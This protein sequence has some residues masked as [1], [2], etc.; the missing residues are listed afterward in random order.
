MSEHLLVIEDSMGIAKVIEKLG[1]SLGYQVTIATTLAQVKSLL[2]NKND[3]FL[4]TVDYGLPDALD[5]EA[6]QF[7]LEHSIPS[8]VMTGRMDDK[9]RQKILNLPVVDYI[10]KENTQAYHYLLRILHCQLTNREISVL[11]VDD[12]L[13]SRNQVS[14]LL[15]RRNFNVFSVEDGTKALALLEEHPEIKIVITDQAMPGMDGLEL[16]QKI[17]KEHSQN[18]L[19]IIGLSDAERSFESARFIKNGADDFLRKP[20]CQ[21]EFYC[22]IMQSI[23]KLKYI[24]EIGAAA[25][26]D[27]LTALYNRRYFLDRAGD[28]HKNLTSTN[29]VYLLAIVYIDDFKNINENVSHEMGDNVIIDTAKLLTQYFGKS[30]IARFGGAEFGLLITK[31]NL[32]AIKNDLEQLRIAIAKHTSTAKN[33]NHQI[34]VS[35]GASTFTDEHPVKMH[36]KK[37]DEALH[38]AIKN[39][40]NQIQMT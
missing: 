15:K 5:G 23:E 17:R 39:G 33:L 6:I 26:K 40:G 4:A 2:E 9:T 13:S 36:M 29:E 8:I 10:T 32:Q 14:L 25:N 7:V 24:E 38:Q 28:V 18:E 11:V 22:R 1:L 12:S 19:I 3:F 27:Y 16:V 20:F 35:I 31:L 21:E 37:A 30:L 34:T